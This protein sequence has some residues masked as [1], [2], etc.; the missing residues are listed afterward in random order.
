MTR[1]MLLLLKDRIITSTVIMM[2][3]SEGGAV[4]VGVEGLMVSVSGDRNRNIGDVVMSTLRIIR[5]N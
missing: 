2:N 1:N 5:C 3:T 4:L